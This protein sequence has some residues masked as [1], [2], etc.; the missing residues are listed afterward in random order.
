VKLREL[1]GKKNP[2]VKNDPNLIA[3]LDDSQTKSEKG[4]RAKSQASD[5]AVQSGAIAVKKPVHWSCLGSV[6]R[7]SSM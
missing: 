3:P 1:T 7:S 5:N 4:L 6:H 2:A